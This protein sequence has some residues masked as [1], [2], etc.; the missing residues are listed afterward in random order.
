MSDEFER[1]P[2][3]GGPDEPDDD[4]FLNWDLQDDSPQ[5][6]GLD[7]KPGPAGD[8]SPLDDELDWQPEPPAEPFPAE[9]PWFAAPTAGD[10]PAQL[11]DDLPPWLQEAAPWD[12][13]SSQAQPEPVD[14]TPDWLKAGEPIAATPRAAPAAPP[15]DDLP[16]WLADADAVAESPPPPAPSTGP[17]PSWLAGLD[18][19]LAGPPLV[20]D[21]GELSEDWL[22]RAEQ[23]PATGDLG[24]TYDEWMAQQA[25]AARRPDVDDE[26]PDLAEAFDE[27]LPPAASTGELPSWSL[28]LE[29][30]DAQAA[31][32]W[33][34][35]VEQAAAPA[36]SSAATKDL[37]EDFDLPVA[38]EPALDAFFEPF[39]SLPAEPAFAEADQEPA[40]AAADLLAGL[41][42]E[43]PTQPDWTA[44]ASAAA[45]PAET[46]PIPAPQDIFDELGLPSPE[47]GYEFLDQPAKTTPEW[48]AEAD[49]APS[50][51]D[52]LEELSELDLSA[53]PAAAPADADLLAELRGAAA[54][55]PEPAAFDLPEPSFEDI[56]SLLA[57]YEAPEMRL[58]ATDRNLLD[59]NP[60]FDRL[61]SDSDL[62]QIA[63][64]RS[65]PAGVTLPDE[66]PGWLA[67]MG[68]TV[69]DVSAAAILRRQAERERPL[70]EL[71]ERLQRL[72][73]RGQE[74]P[75]P[76]DAEPS[77]ALKTLLPGVKQFIAPTP[78]RAG[79][80][81]LAGELALSEQ[82]LEKVALLRTLVAVE[83][84]AASRG[85][86]PSA[87]DLTYEARG[88]EEALEAEL[89]PITGDEEAVPATTPAAAPRRLKVDRLLISLLLG[90]AVLL[91]FFVGALRIGQLPPVAFAAGSRQQAVFD[92]LNAL[93]PGDLALIAAEY[94]PTGAGELDGLLDAVL[95]HALLRGARPVLV[96][97]NPLGVLHAQNVVDR[98]GADPTFTAQLGRSLQNER[99]YVMVRYLAGSVIGLRAFSQN[100]EAALS[101]SAAGTA[102]GL[103]MTTV[104]DFAV[105]VVVAERAEDVRAWAEQVTAPTGRLLLAAVSQAAAPLA[106]PY[107]LP[108]SPA[109]QAS[110]GGLLVGYRDSY[111]YHALL[112]PAL[113]GERLLTPEGTVP[114]DQSEAAATVA[115]PPTEVVTPTAAPPTPT[116]AGLETGEPAPTGEFAAT[117]LPNV[118]ETAGSPTPTTGT[119]E[120]AALPVITGVITAESAVNVREGPARTFVPVAAL[121]PGT[122]LQVIGRTADSLWYQVRLEDGRE[123]WISAELLTLEEP[124]A[125]ATATPVPTAAARRDAN[126]VV[127]LMS[128]AGFERA[129]AQEATPEPTL[130]P[131]Q[132]AAAAASEPASPAAPVS[133]VS[134][135]YR[136]ER[137]Y[138]MT[139]GL[140]AASAVIAL[141]A[142]GNIIRSL[143]RRRR[144]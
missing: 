18:E 66:A 26:V 102:T 63:A 57:S 127:S 107:L 28:G 42:L 129:A 30:L 77:E 108:G 46:G 120:A 8:E 17:L 31:P 65:G 45:A 135:A 87:I 105:V 72:H 94:G 103:A 29:E 56:D 100:L 71:N 33:M 109:A 130:E 13:P 47:T 142:A 58:P 39:D 111:T 10:Q 81:G 44:L 143:F 5:D 97:T 92:S 114:A 89:E 128:D 40:P 14:D 11:D 76:A 35:E 52:W 117:G 139:L 110:Y 134:L 49:A 95:R 9:E 70:D 69:A 61:L 131:A 125:A 112:E 22:A 124:A 2:P 138:G 96:S 113:S 119:P 32:D 126:A 23:V 84:E 137:W 116:S 41:E 98:L 62:E 104:G 20:S 36:A 140:A 91:P 53:P 133:G 67:E 12:E 19:E 85:Q 90:L 55:E 21:T 123:G 79:L 6:S 3:P 99:D 1:R 4:E 88:L 38:P 48:F 7:W 43:P 115:P 60:D 141:G 15:D 24:L 118:T 64:R 78:A 132:P 74:L 73:E 144:R 16:P 34:Q 82:Q 25:A 59:P 83:D 54:P 122:R 27:A 106:E 50:S 75:P 37:F 80:P 136:D 93:R 51:P 101:T 121:Q 68:A 86:P